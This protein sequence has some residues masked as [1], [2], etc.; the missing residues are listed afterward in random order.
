MDILSVI[1]AV[2]TIAAAIVIPVMLAI[3]G[4]KCAAAV[5]EREIQSRYIELCMGML[6]ESPSTENV[7]LR[8]WAIKVVNLYAPVK[9]SEKEEE[10]AFKYKILADI[11][12]LKWGPITSMFSK[13]DSKP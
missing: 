10:E 3:V 7:R 11:E 13:T 6:K 1:Q 4:N 5:K 8:R 2:A 12:R 9:L